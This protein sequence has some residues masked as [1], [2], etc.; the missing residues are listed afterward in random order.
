MKIAFN[1]YKLYYCKVF[2][3]DPAMQSSIITKGRP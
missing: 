3:V 1:I 2:I